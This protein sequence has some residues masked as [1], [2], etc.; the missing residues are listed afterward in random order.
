MPTA[1]NVKGNCFDS[2]SILE[3]FVYAPS[4][5]DDNDVL[6]FDQYDQTDYFAFFRGLRYNTGA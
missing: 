6:I 5:T 1:S 3:G 2:S 4:D